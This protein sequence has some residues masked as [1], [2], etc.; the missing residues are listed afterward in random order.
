M[1]NVSEC[2]PSKCECYTM[3]PRTLSAEP[4]PQI[5]ATQYDTLKQTNVTK[6]S[7]P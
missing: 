3:L 5:S 6:P 2:C 7:N 4:P 1:Q